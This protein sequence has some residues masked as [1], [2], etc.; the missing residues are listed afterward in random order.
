MIQVR[1][2]ILKQKRRNYVRNTHT[3][4]IERNKICSPVIP[5]IHFRCYR[6]E[7]IN[8]ASMNTENC[9]VGLSKRFNTAFILVYIKMKEY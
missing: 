1:K 3:Y 7:L 9:V 4:F 2:G 5:E 8:L 6:T